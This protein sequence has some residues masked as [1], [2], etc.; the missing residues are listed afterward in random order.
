MVDRSRP[1]TALLPDG[2]SLI[3]AGGD[4]TCGQAPGGAMFCWGANESGQ[5]GDG[6]TSLRPT[7]TRI[8]VV[9]ATGLALGAAHTIIA[10]HDG[11]ADTFGRDDH[12]QLGDSRRAPLDAT[13]A[14]LPAPL[15]GA[16]VVASVAA[17]GNFTCVVF[18]DGRLR[19]SGNL[20]SDAA[21]WCP[22]NDTGG[23]PPVSEA[24]VGL[25]H[26]CARSQS[27]SVF[28][29]GE[30][31]NGQ[32]GDGSLAQRPDWTAVMLAMPARRIAAAASHTCAILT[33]ASLWCWGSNQ[34]GELGRDGLT[35]SP[36]PIAV[37][38][39]EGAIDVATGIDFTCAIGASGR[40]YCWG[41]GG[42]G[43]LGDGSTSD[44]SMPRLV[45]L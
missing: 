21:E 13:P 44:R 9:G 7:P 11:S 6:T 3:A 28:C 23:L 45:D 29:R 32:V 31:L 2:A 12:C 24:A 27:G 20:W 19:C 41:A 42:H 18:Q 26:M 37:A 15:D 35:V 10:L 38:L 36:R 1:I 25:I 5:L 4:H 40:V 16:G 14:P 33:D 30:N 22:P 34:S 39:G 43:Q 17:G 8:G